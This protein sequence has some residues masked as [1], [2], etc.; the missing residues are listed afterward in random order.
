MEQL[1]AQT[2]WDVYPR[3]IT[4]WK[5]AAAVIGLALCASL[6]L[7]SHAENLAA[8]G[9]M[10]LSNVSLNDGKSLDL[11]PTI[12]SAQWENNQ[13]YSDPVP[14]ECWFPFTKPATVSAIG[15]T[16]HWDPIQDG[17]VQS[18]DGAH[19]VTVCKLPLLDGSLQGNSVRLPQPVTSYGLRVLFTKIGNGDHDV[20]TLT[21]LNIEGTLAAPERLYQTTDLTLSCAQPMNIFDLPAPAAVAIGVGNSLGN[22]TRYRLQTSWRTPYGDACGQ[23]DTQER[24]TLGKGET[25]QFPARFS[26]RQQGPYCVTV[27]LFDDERQVLLAVRRL[28]VGMRDPHILAQGTVASYEKPGQRIIP[29]RERQRQLQCIWGSE[30][31]HCV[32]SLQRR[33]GEGYFATMEAAGAD[34]VSA[35]INYSDFEPLPGVYNF[36]YF[37][38]LIET[39]KAH[40]LGL[41]LGLWRWEFGGPLQTWLKGEVIVNRQG[42]NAGGWDNLYSCW[43]PEY[44]RHMF[45]AVEVL[46]KRYKNSPTVWMWN[47][48][49]YGQVD[50]DYHG[51]DDFSTYARAAFPKFLARRYQQLSKLNTAYHASYTDWAQVPM[52]EPLWRQ[53]QARKEYAAMARVLDTRPAWRDY[54]DFLQ[55]DGVMG[56]HIGLNDLVHRLDPLRGIEGIH[57]SLGVGAADDTLKAL[58]RE[59]AYYGETGMQAI[60]YTRTL[61]AKQRYGLP[62]RHEDSSTLSPSRFPLEQVDARSQWDMFQ[63]CIYGTEHFNFVFPTW[64]KSRFFDTV[65]ANP[66]AKA[67]AKEAATASLISRPVAH[68]HCFTTDNLEGN[69]SFNGISVYR[70]WIMNAFSRAMLQPG[71]FFEPF[72]AAGPLRDLDRMKLVIDDGTRVMTPEVLARLVRFVKKGGKLVMTP[73][74][75]ERVTGDESSNYPLLTA[76]GYGDTHGLHAL[77]YGRGTI[78]FSAGNGVFR[79][80]RALPVHDYAALVPPPGAA[81]VGTIAGTPGAVSWAYGAGRVLL[82]A[83]LPGSIS[84]ADY[85][86]AAQADDAATK[87][88]AGAIWTD[89]E[90]ELGQ[91]LPALTH[92]LGEWAQVP[93]TFDITGTFSACDKQAGAVR[94]IYLYNRGEACAPTLRVQLAPRTY[95]MELASLTA[96]VPLKPVTAAELARGIALPVLVPERLY[97]VRLRPAKN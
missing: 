45:R 32:S 13:P 50:H 68:L 76:L 38:R 60:H 3:W 73:A 63:N 86:V 40:H 26:T 95:T 16:T 92:D 54:L 81:V 44:R 65:F 14:L 71:E 48:H 78:A 94:L 90:T 31:Y 35:T 17:E 59:G 67:L 82:L 18:W 69:Y 74:T 91:V 61:I 83:G 28:V 84:A 88:T 79:S 46:V 24:F 2:M 43:G 29:I 11:F 58:A 75:G 47:P 72:S 39:A 33:P 19:W 51:I 10:V 23:A 70:W 89:A 8:K 96:T 34:I 53:A 97:V 1:V 42:V 37:D 77:N 30:V 87:K 36:A 85:E 41:S 93:P 4:C 15:F 27:S 20:L 52:P 22:C 56:V 55:V 25:R 80:L 5:R 64:E 6:P 62:G 21:G 12:G 7:V 57:C 66:R 9:N 49:P